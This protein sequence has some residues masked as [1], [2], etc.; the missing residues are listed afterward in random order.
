MKSTIT[1]ADW[2][3]RLGDPNLCDHQ[4]LELKATKM[5]IAWEN[6]AAECRRI[7]PVGIPWFTR[8]DWEDLDFKSR[9]EVLARMREPTRSAPE[10]K[11]VSM[12]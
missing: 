5:K 7:D 1:L 8:R 12:W 6:Y 9:L 3:V 10:P 11:K 2:E 4:L